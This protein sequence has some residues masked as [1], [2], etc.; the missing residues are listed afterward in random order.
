ME[1]EGVIAEG[2][3][4]E[5]CLG[6]AIEA[7]KEN[8]WRRTLQE[9]PMR[10]WSVESAIKGTGAEVEELQKELECGQRDGIIDEC[11]DGVYGFWCYKVPKE[12]EWQ[13]WKAGRA[14]YKRMQDEGLKRIREGCSR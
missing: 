11:G 12:E 5:G 6:E 14:C 13:I 9:C 3:R 7:L 1:G 2:Y 8:Y 10:T 4:G